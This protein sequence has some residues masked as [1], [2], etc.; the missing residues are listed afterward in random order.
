MAYS[1]VQYT[2]NG[3]IKTF[4]VPFTYI[5]KSHIAVKVNGVLKAAGT[6]YSWDTD[7]S[8]TF[9][10]APGTGLTV[11]IRRASSPSQR[12]IDFQ[13]GSTLTQDILDADSNQNF[14]MAQEAIDAVASNIALASD[15]VYDANNKRIKNLADPINA[16]DAV[17][18]NWAETASSSQVA[19]AT[20][21]AN[22][23]ASSA[24]AS[25]TS[26]AAS[27][28]SAT[29]ASGSAATATTK[30]TDS[31]NSATASAASAAAA[32]TS[33][34]AAATSETNAA[35]SASSAS[36]SATAANTSAVN[37]ATSASGASA[38]ASTATTKASDA[39]GS[40]TAASNSASAAATSATNAAS[41]ASSA[42]S[43]ATTAATQ[44]TNSA[45]SATAAA[46]SATSAST[47]A[48][49]ATTKA[50]EASTSAT[51]AATSATN[52]ASSATSAATSASDANTSAVSAASSAA[53]AAAL[54][55]NFDDRYLGS[56]T[57]APTLDNDGNALLIGALYFD[58]T[59]GKMRVYTASG[60]LDASSAS[61]A[62]L[63]VF[64]YT[65]TAGQTSFSGA[66][67]ASQSLTYTVGSLFVTLNGIDLK[68]GADYTATTGSSIVLTSGA[69]A[70]DELRVYAF[71][72]FLVADTY[73]RAE[74][75]SLLSAKQSAATAVAKDSSTGAAILP[76]GTTAQ[77][78][79]SPTNGMI[80]YNTTTTKVEA[81]QNGGWVNYALSYDIE[82]LIVA[83]GGGGSTTA[84]GG[85]GGG[86]FVSASFSVNSAAS[87][88][89]VVG[90]GGAGAG[91]DGGQG[92]PGSNSS[93]GSITALGGGGG[94]HGIPTAGGCG[95]GGGYGG[96]TAGGAG[97][98]GQ[99]YAGG[100][101]GNINAPDY[102]CGGGG[103]AGGVGGSVTLGTTIGGLGGA[104]QLWLNGNYYAGGGGGSGTG[105][106]AG[107]VGGGGRGGLVY[108][109][110]KLPGTA[111]TGGGGGGGGGGSAI[112]NGG[113][114][115]VIVRYIGS[116]KGTGGTVT[117]SGGYTYHTFTSSGTFTA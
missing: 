50:G 89:A 42:S 46:G 38:S 76:L 39:S 80:R 75:D 40:A 14:F 101:G 96:V 16:Q 113:S 109:G 83:G 61:V 56:K 32:L 74:A 59:T 51:N 115:V 27:A 8:I 111:N 48:T 67:I 6:D 65:A 95:G 28:A 41:S 98:S 58:S 55:D 100:S 36:S 112:G 82:Y 34:N 69:V 29:S 64:N 53:S 87:Y 25:A 45:S 12:L 7:S 106:A 43:S 26:A 5:S 70:G 77:R 108:D 116:Q 57:S 52:A 60:W 93:F 15:G 54:L 85:G 1:Y 73:T 44:A 49:T 66:D 94:G 47:S 62:T 102:P 22:N 3:S 72:S 84:G 11:D 18:K 104:G 92:I 19:Q 71:G 88:S 21:Q 13:D 110:S 86:G 33:K 78:P 91:S 2:G 97:T 81:Y 9:V 79:S 114:G 17:S 37:A 35:S 23:S 31:S 24:A 68:N 107:G 105:N 99:G 30:A 20:T 90:S 10:T 103:G 117:S 63:A 4:S